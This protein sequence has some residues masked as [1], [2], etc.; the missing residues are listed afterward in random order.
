MS[1][2]RNEHAPFG[3]RNRNRTA[4]RG[5][6]VDARL[7]RGAYGNVSFLGKSIAYRDRGN[8][9]RSAKFSMFLGTITQELHSLW[10]PADPT[11]DRHQ[12]K[13]T[14]HIGGRGSSVSAGRQIDSNL[15][16]ASSTSCF[17]K[18]SLSPMLQISRSSRW[19]RS[20]GA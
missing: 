17:I 14:R 2:A 19:R 7:Y 8:S 13:D 11:R 6:A 1:S 3:G 5:F 12:A 15:A 16:T 10:H 20:G 4:V 9:P 18:S